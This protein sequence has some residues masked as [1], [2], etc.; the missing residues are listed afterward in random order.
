MRASLFA[1]GLLAIGLSHC[2]GDRGLFVGTDRDDDGGGGESNENGGTGAGTTGGTA[3]ASNGGSEN[4]GGTENTGGAPN[5]GGTGSGAE[6]GEP[7]GG[8][9]GTD[10]GG[11]H[12]GGTDAGGTDGGGAGGARA[13]MGGSGAE[14]GSGTAGHAGTNDGGRAGAAGSNNAG[15]GGGSDVDCEALAREYAER[16]AAAQQCSLQLTVE[17]CTIEMPNDFF[18]PC[19]TYVNPMRESDIRRMNEILQRKSQC[20]RACPTIACPDYKRGTCSMNTAIVS[21]GLGRCAA[22]L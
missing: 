18:C 8:T 7:S 4:S 5:R 10:S 20:V 1:L 12:A 15:A 21:P 3:G 16:L 13:G 11:T 6:A 19:K 14:A 9:G 22:V 17:Q 2:S